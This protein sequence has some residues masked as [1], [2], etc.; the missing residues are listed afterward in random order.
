MRSAPLSPRAPEGPTAAAVV[1]LAVAGD[2]VEAVPDGVAAPAPF[3]AVVVVAAPL[4]ALDD[5]LLEL[6]ELL[7]QA[8]SRPASKGAA[9]PRAAPRR[10]TARR[11]NR[12]ASTSCRS[13]ANAGAFFMAPTSSLP[14]R[15][16]TETLQAD[17]RAPD[18]GL[19][20]QPTGQKHRSTNFE[21]GNPESAENSGSAGFE[22]PEFL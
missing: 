16:Q 18:C 19:R 5:E 4:D 8:A 12:P 6:L 17:C 2:V 1:A 14:H 9:S 11:L 13:S 10:K 3:V 15:R 20:T 22:N 21:A 7:P